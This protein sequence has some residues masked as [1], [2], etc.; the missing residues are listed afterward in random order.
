MEKNV[1]K[2]RSLYK[3]YLATSAFQIFNSIIKKQLVW[4]AIERQLTDW[5]AD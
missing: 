3:F 4:T 2:P 5:W 1:I